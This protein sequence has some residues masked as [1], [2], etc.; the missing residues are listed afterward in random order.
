MGTDA[1]AC[2]PTGPPTWRDSAAS[3]S[4]RAPS[5]DA[6]AG[7]TASRLAPA[8]SNAARRRSAS[9]SNAARS[10]ASSIRDARTRG[11]TVDPDRTADVE[12]ADRFG[13]ISSPAHRQLFRIEISVDVD[14]GHRRRRRDPQLA[15]GELH[16][17]A[18]RLVDEV[19]P[20]E[21]CQLIGRRREREFAAGNR[22]RLARA[23][24][25]DARQRPLP[26]FASGDGLARDFDGDAGAFGHFRRTAREQ[27]FAA[28]IV[29]R[30]RVTSTGADQPGGNHA[31]GAANSI[32]LDPRL[33]DL[34]IVDQRRAGLTN[35]ALDPPFRQCRTR[36]FSAAPAFRR[37]GAR[38]R[39][40]S[41]RRC[42]G[43]RPRRNPAAHSRRPCRATRRG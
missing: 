7:W 13:R 39:S 29:A 36:R 43:H 1:S 28:I 30:D 25:G 31:S 27:I 32:Q 5:T 38:P 22:R 23:V 21:P 10:C 4:G 42:G 9:A 15:P 17:S 8:G 18:A 12:A 16:G 3:Q 2:K 19:V 11:R 24:L 33:D 37:A 40:N 35:P 20:A 14:Q 6:T 41:C 26:K 34:A